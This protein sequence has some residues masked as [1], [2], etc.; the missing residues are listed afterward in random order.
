MP[1]VA[2][3]NCCPPRLSS[4]KLMLLKQPVVHCDTEKWHPWSG[5]SLHSQQLQAAPAVADV[6]RRLAWNLAQQKECRRAWW[7]QLPRSTTAVSR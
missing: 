1:T 7:I 5:P 2:V 6:L 4:Q 3:D